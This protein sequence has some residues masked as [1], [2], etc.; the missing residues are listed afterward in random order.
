MKKTGVLIKKHQ[1]RR[2][3]IQALGALVINGNF[4]NFFQGKIYQGSLKQ[5]CLPVLNCYSCPGAFGSCPIGAL[6]A[7]SN[8]PKFQ[9]SYFVVGFLTLSGIVLGRWFCGWLCPFGWIQEL[10]H[11]IPLKKFLPPA[12]TDRVFRYLKYLFLVIF[13]LFIPIFIAD[14]FGFG[15]PAFCKLICPAGTLEAGIPLLLANP[16]LRQAI[17]FLFNWKLLLLLLTLIGSIFIFRFFCKY[18]C[19]LGAIYGLFNRISFLQ[20]HCSDRCIK[21]NAC[22]HICKMNVEPYKNPQ[23]AECIRCG[24]CL[25]VC[26]VNALEFRFKKSESKDKHVS[27]L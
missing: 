13:V 27:D 10:L 12:K 23:S 11:K 5:F 2:F 14:K 25:K 18:A 7:V 1:R 24:D 19:P 8:D 20:L 15:Y 9:L 17:G 26:P 3:L 16:L 4:N 22:S 6:Q 21:C